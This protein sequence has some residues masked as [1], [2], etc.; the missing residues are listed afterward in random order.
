VTRSRTDTGF[1]L[2][3]QALDMLYNAYAQ[4]T[5]KCSSENHHAYALFMHVK[6]DRIERASYSRGSHKIQYESATREVQTAIELYCAF[7]TGKSLEQ[8]TGAGLLEIA[9]AHGHGA[10]GLDLKS[11]RERLA[12]LGPGGPEG[13]E[14]M[15]PLRR[16]LGDVVF[17]LLFGGAVPFVLFNWAA[18]NLQLKRI[19]ESV[20]GVGPRDRIHFRDVREMYAL[21]E[22]LHGQPM[23][24]RR[25]RGLELG[26]RSLHLNKVD[27]SS[28]RSAYQRDTY[29]FFLAEAEERGFLSHFEVA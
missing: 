5:A 10:A 26:V 2:V 22:A 4:I 14:A 11:V 16:E 24:S 25:G 13:P 12:T 28:L 20:L 29:D 7:A 19:V 9:A 3:D 27:E 6:D 23:L 18:V 1:F 17:S 8:V 15:E 21:L